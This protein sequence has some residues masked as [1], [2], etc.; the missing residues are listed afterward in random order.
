[1]ENIVAHSLEKLY[2]D[3][4]KQIRFSGFRHKKYG[5]IMEKMLATISNL[6]IRKEPAIRQYMTIELKKR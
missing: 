1:M 4:E 5:H 2:I 3:F 6:E